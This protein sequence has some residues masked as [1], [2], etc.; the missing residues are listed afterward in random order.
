MSA[1]DT[2]AQLLRRAAA[3]LRQD[4]EAA[5]RFVPEP[6]SITED[7]VIRAANDDIVADRSS[8]RPGDDAD[9]PFIAAMHPGVGM[10]LAD[11]IDEQAAFNEYFVQSGLPTLPP[12]RALAVARQLLGEVTR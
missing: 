6:W 9:L 4:A 5:R 10:A 8:C 7:R 1:T 11:W 2:P 3:K 12:E